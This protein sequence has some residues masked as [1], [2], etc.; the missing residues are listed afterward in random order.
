MT[1]SNISIRAAFIGTL[2]FT[3]TACQPPAQQL[4]PAPPPPQG[5]ALDAAV[6]GFVTDT[7][8][9]DRFIAGRPT[10]AA[11]RQRYPDVVLVLPGDITTQEIRS[12]NSR[13]FAELDDGQRIIGG[14]FQ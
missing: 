5:A 12:N 10:V 13:F 6:Q 3:A 8:S 14:R 11:F 1:P 9:F 4:P 7:A 2:L